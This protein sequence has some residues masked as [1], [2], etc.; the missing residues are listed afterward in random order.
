MATH[1]NVNNDTGPYR[2]PAGIANENSRRILYDQATSASCNTSVSQHP[3]V[4]QTLSFS[5]QP[6]LHIHNVTMPK[7]RDVLNDIYAKLH[8]LESLPSIDRRLGQ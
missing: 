6:F 2:T 5:D 7:L 4:Q 8:S 1:S 3:S